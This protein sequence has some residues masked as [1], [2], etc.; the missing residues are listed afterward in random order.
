MC[1]L[2]SS[3]LCNCNKVTADG[4]ADVACNT[5]QLLHRRRVAHQHSMIMFAA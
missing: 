2:H 1:Y 5:S 3:M 4:I